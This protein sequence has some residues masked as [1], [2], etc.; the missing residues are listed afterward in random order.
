RQRM[1]DRQRARQAR[2]IGGAVVAG[3]IAPAVGGVVGGRENWLVEHGCLLLG[4][5][6]RRSGEPAGLMIHV[7]QVVVGVVPQSI[8]SPL[9][10][11]IRVG[12]G[13]PGTAPRTP[14]KEEGGR[15]YVA[16]PRDLPAERRGDHANAGKQ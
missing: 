11:G 12:G 8:S 13:I 1:A 16:L 7:E 4:T 9:S 10:G 2:H 6:P 3:N 15:S 14:H 5:W